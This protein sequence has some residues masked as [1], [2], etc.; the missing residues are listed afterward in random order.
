MKRILIVAALMSA[1]SLV[2]AVAQ[3]MSK[4]DLIAQAVSAAPE[5]LR[6]GATVVTYDAKGDPE[7]LR[8]GTNDIVCTPNQNKDNYSVNCYAKILRAQRDLQAKDKALG[9]DAKATAADIQAANLPKPPVGTTMYSLSG[10]TQATARG[11]WVVLVPGMTAAES[12]LPTKPTAA[13]TPWLMRAG[14][15]GAHIHMPQA[16]ASAASGGAMAPM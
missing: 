5:E 7:V 9:K 3:G 8:Q 10:K 1:A 15:P 12:G 4:D 16:A 14:T 6:A 2:P 11:M 13:G